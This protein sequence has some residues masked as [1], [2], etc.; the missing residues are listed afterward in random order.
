MKTITNINQLDLEHTYTYA[1]Y[2]MW[3][4]KERIELIKGRVFAM[5]PAPSQIHQDISTRLVGELYPFFKTKSCKLFSAPF[6]VRL[7]TKDKEDNKITTVV[8]PDICVIC[9]PNKLDERGCL[10][11][12]DLIVEILSPGNSKKEMKI[13]YELYEENGVEEY[14]VVRPYE[15]S[16]QVFV[17]DQGK[18][19]LEKTYVDDDVLTSKKFNF[20]IDLREIFN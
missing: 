18:Y 6:D 1:D 19:R 9:D 13:K 7:T 12:P 3:E 10:G 14:W 5:S 8:Q 11:S 15:K 20:Q 2:L 4:I 16:V 17:L